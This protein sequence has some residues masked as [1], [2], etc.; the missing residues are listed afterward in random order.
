MVVKDNIRPSP[1]PRDADPPAP[2]PPEVDPPD[3]ERADVTAEA[4][5]DREAEVG[6]VA[7][8]RRS[9]GAVSV[10]ALLTVAVL[11]VGGLLAVQVADNADRDNL[12]DS[13]AEFAGQQALSL[14]TISGKDVKDRLADIAGRS[15]GEFR[16]QLV[17]MQKTFGEIVKR[18]EVQSAGVIDSVAVG[19]L[20]A[21]KARVLLALTAKVSNAQ[22]KKAQPRHYRIIVDLERKED[23]WL[24]AGMRFVP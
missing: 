6:S 19:E 21:E 1:R 14:L 3:A 10:L 9:V 17:G 15:T 18:G 5:A 23:Q 13:A 22:T 11:V 24:V 8:G 16:R 7:R 2:D 20:S 4:V 12:R